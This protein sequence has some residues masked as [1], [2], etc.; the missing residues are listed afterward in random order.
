MINPFRKV[1]WNPGTVERRKF[2]VSLIIGFPCIALVVLVG[3]RLA[4]GAWHFAT[5]LRLAGVGAA[6]GAALWLLPAVAKPF[7]V[8]WYFVSCCIGF[9]VSNVLLA[10][11][12]YVFFTTAGLVL[13]AVGR[14]P[15]Q[16]GFDA[17][18]TSY[19]RSADTIDDPR[20]YFRQF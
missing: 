5:P 10:T 19:W 13:G 20:R 7:Y 4:S 11:F 15:L 12:Y 18:A 6:V 9:V 8:I 3:N 2:A 17:R 14:R 1:D 16:T